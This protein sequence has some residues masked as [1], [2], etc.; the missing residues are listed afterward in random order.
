MKYWI[1]VILLILVVTQNS[2]A[3]DKSFV[4]GITVN[5]GVSWMQPENSYF[6][7]EGAVFSFGYGLDFDFYFSKNYALSTG[8]QVLNWGGKASYPDLYPQG[9]SSELTQVRSTSEYKYSAL[10][11][12][13]FVTLKTNPIGYNSYFAEFGFSFLFPYK[14]AISTTSTFPDGFSTDR[15]T[16]SIFD[17]TPFASVNIYLGAGIELPISGKTKVKISL[18]F[19]NGISSLSSGKAFKTDGNGNVANEE[20]ENG[21]VP[22][23]EKLVYFLKGLYINFRVVF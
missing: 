16:S 15:G 23:G 9:A 8:L 19:L 20:I 4:I 3:Q 10:Q 11:V 18:Q 2:I 1:I 17:N 12:P 13:L 22:S 6:T 21:G 5:P 7:S 14:T